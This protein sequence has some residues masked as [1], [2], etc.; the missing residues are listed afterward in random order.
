[1]TLSSTVHLT[2]AVIEKVIS[3]RKVY[4]TCCTHIDEFRGMNLT[5]K[6]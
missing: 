5:L 4:K 1:M 3:K 2:F 6:S